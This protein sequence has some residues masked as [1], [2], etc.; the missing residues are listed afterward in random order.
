MET[1]GYWELM[2]GLVLPAAWNGFE[3]QMLSQGTNEVQ[4]T[5]WIPKC[6]D[7]L[8]SCLYIEAN[9]K[10]LKERREANCLPMSLLRSLF[11]IW[12][13]RGGVLLSLLM[14]CVNIVSDFASNGSERI[15]GR[16]S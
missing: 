15:L 2:G 4:S 12:A 1:F 14:T 11:P 13:V 10:E 6:L 7:W 9:V 16:A 3:L 5:T 8:S